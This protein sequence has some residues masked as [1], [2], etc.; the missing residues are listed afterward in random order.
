MRASGKKVESIKGERGESVSCAVPDPHSEGWNGPH[1]MPQRASLSLVSL[2][3]KAG[4]L[5]VSKIGPP[6]ADRTIQLA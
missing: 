6:D 1:L 4:P 2:L 3:D 5:E